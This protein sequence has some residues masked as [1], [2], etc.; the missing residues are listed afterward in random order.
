MS[1]S[2]FNFGITELP[3]LTGLK[4]CDFHFHLILDYAHPRCIEVNKFG[5]TALTLKK[6]RTVKRKSV[7]RKT[8]EMTKKQK[9]TN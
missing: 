1:L 6:L 5:I 7:S 4:Q 2:V 3:G 8:T 9:K